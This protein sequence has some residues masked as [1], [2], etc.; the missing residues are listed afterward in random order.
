MKLFLLDGFFAGSGNDRRLTSPTDI[1]GIQMKDFMGEKMLRDSSHPYWPTDNGQPSAIFFVASISSV[2]HQVRL[3]T[4]NAKKDCLLAR[5]KPIVYF[6][7]SQK[8]FT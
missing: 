5:H 8:T 2:P 3:H 1:P 7:N 6:N 4:Y